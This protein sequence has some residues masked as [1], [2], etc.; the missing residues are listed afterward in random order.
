MVTISCY[1]LLYLFGAIDKNR[2]KLVQVTKIWI[3]DAR[4]TQIETKV[5]V[6]NTMFRF[7]LGTSADR[8][9]IKKRRKD[10]VM[11]YFDY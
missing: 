6:R 10:N 1:I 9:K 3:C 2:I 5:S 7:I 4:H 8:E 11:R